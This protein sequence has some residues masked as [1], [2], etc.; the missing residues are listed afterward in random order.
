MLKYLFERKN[1]DILEK[2]NSENRYTIKNKDR[3]PNNFE[4]F[5]GFL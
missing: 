3:V 2:K 4:G 1:N 5:I